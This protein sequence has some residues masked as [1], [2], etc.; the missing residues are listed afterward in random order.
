MNLVSILMIS[1]ALAL[2]AFSVCV[3]A[4]IVIKNLNFGHYFRLSFSF[5]FFQFIMPIL[6]YFCGK[7]IEKLIKSFD[8]W[9]ALALLFFV[10]CK[11][12]KEAFEEDSEKAFK[13]KD[14]SKGFSLLILSIATSIDALAVGL[15]MGILNKPILYPSIIIGLTCSLFSIAGI[16]IG[17]KVRHFA[18]N[19]IANIIGGLMLIL[20][21]I[22]ILLEHM[23]HVF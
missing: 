23:D 11:M 1:I 16:M 3:S 8:H 20:I 22:K 10:G 5:G 12:I 18:G 13:S 14:P 15:S 6:G 7:H 4:G 9:I 21:G 2:D 17:S 19:K